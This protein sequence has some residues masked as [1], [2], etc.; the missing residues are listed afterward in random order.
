MR[1]FSLHP[2]SEFLRTAKKGHVMLCCNFPAG[3]YWYFPL[4][5]VHVKSS[6]EKEW[7]SL[8]WWLVTSVNHV[9]AYCHGNAPQWS[10]GWGLKVYR[11][12]FI[13]HHFALCFVTLLVIQCT[14]EWKGESSFSQ[15]ISYFGRTGIQIDVLLLV[16]ITVMVCW[17]VCVKWALRGCCVLQCSLF[18]KK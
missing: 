2:E 5:G 11:V 6:L 18:I 1:T 4:L 13:P 9:S 8:L 15:N 17:H 10:P 12:E 7:K 14:W 3:I 16:S